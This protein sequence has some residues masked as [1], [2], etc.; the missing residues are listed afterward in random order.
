MIT[1]TRRGFLIGLG[2]GIALLA[3]PPIVRA[4]SIMPVKVIPPA[5]IRRKWYHVAITRA[6]NELTAF[7]NGERVDVEDWD[8]GLIR[9]PH[10]LRSLHTP[11]RGSHQSMMM[12][13]IE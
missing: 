1:P 13:G 4:S 7:I 10:G 9:L 12:V 5:P 3:A 6:D 11:P 8:K 2:T